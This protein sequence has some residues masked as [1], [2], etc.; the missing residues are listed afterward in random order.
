MPPKLTTKVFIEKARE[1]H[2]DKFDYSKIE[3][4]DG[5][6][7][8]TVI[9][10]EHGEFRPWPSTFL[11]GSGCKKC[12]V[13]DAKRYVIERSKE[14]FKQK[15]KLVHGYI[16]DYSKFDY[17]RSD[18]KSVIICAKHGEFMMNPN[19]H[20]SGR[21]C[22]S[23]AN[24]DRK[25]ALVARKFNIT[26]SKTPIICEQLTCTF[27]EKAI[28]EHGDRYD[29]SNSQYVNSSTKV[30]IICHEH[31]EFMQQPSLHLRGAGCKK[32]ADIAKGKKRSKIAAEQFIQRA[33][34]V[35][36]DYYEYTK[37]VYKK[38]SQKVVI[39]CYKHGDFELRPNNHLRGVGCAKCAAERVADQ[40]RMTLEEFI[41]RASM[42]HNNLYD[43][44][45][46]VY[47]NSA[48]KVIIICSKHGEFKQTAIAHLN[49]GGCKAC[50]HERT[51]ASKSYD[52]TKFIEDAKAVHG[53]KFDY[54]MVKY[55]GSAKPVTVICPEHGP[56]TTTYEHHAKRGQ[57]CP[58]CRN[59]DMDTDKFIQRS[60]EIHGDKYDYS[61]AK[62]TVAKGRVCII[63]PEHGDFKQVAW[64][65]MDGIGC[66]YCFDW[67]NSKGSQRIESWL[68][69]N[70]IDF[71]REKKFDDLYTFSTSRKYHLRFDFFIPN[72]NLLIEY[73]GKQHFEPVEIFGGN[74]GYEKLLSNDQK[75]RDW[76]DKCGY[77]L[78]RIA[79][80]DDDNIE[81]ILNDH[82]SIV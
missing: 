66:P 12:N 17:Q 58:S 49:G 45:K 34:E 50:G 54:S 20:L 76:V 5:K 67:Q 35:H 24:E 75:K 72:C 28:A 48:E 74:E 29:Y 52:K 40:Q 57:S 1:V 82:I 81:Q 3:Y 77:K 19:N 60:R 56:F 78:L 23:C 62:Y 64:N 47:V 9:C 7:P 46:V 69:E 6:T 38:S 55:K 37:V 18:L 10:L 51:N 61:K 44:S 39:T 31:G 4:V 13:R 63:C 21:G 8:I 22:P 16:Y 43:Y 70:D 11:R 33:R 59:R 25:R 65:H 36:D 41:S 27:I 2:G 73:D 26:P 53:E 14:A 30:A 42:V 71:E 15:A 80:S 32:C 68:K 79:Y